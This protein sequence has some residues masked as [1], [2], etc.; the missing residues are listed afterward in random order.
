MRTPKLN[1]NSLCQ[2]FDMFGRH[3]EF[4]R[5]A[6][7]TRCFSMIPRTVMALLTGEANPG[8]LPDSCLPQSVRL[9]TAL[10][11]RVVVILADGFGWNLVERLEHLPLVEEGRKN[12]VVSRITS[13]FPSTTSAHVT[14]ISTNLEPIEHGIFEWNTYVPELGE[15]FQALPYRVVRNGVEIP[16][17]EDVAPP[18]L[19]FPRPTFYETL[20]NKGIKSLV[21]QNASIANSITS[22]F[23]TSG[24]SMDSY[25]DNNIEKLAEKWPAVMKRDDWTYCFIYFPHVDANSHKHGPSSEK[26][27]ETA[28]HVTNTILDIIKASNGSNTLFLITADHGQIDVLPGKRE[29]RI[30]L[31]NELPQIE[32]MLEAHPTVPGR[33][34]PPTG[35]LRNLFLHVQSQHVE[36]VVEALNHTYG[37]Y[38]EAFSSIPLINDSIF[39]RSNS[40]KYLSRLG[41][42]SI[43]PRKHYTVFLSETT[44]SCLD[45]LGSHGGAHPEEM[46]IPLIALVT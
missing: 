9:E 44:M 32:A 6:Y 18:G 45:H 15:I 8:T 20:A 39:G 19:I 13:Q 2:G 27:A 30:C 41:T 40:Q 28:L 29:H 1:P 46:I 36:T 7:S 24:T 43:I 31:L 25:P 35:N 17:S 16:V 22:K 34:I 33:R 14:T 42:V 23:I 12:G 3:K 4:V 21:I 37:E 26:V 38:L 5:P 10:P 11:Q